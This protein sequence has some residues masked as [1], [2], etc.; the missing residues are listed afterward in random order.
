[1]LAFFYYIYRGVDITENYLAE[2]G[3]R[4]MILKLGAKVNHSSVPGYYGR[5]EAT[6]RAALPLTFEGIHSKED[7]WDW[8]ENR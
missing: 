2:R 8:F 4:E 1:M 3:M 7:F 6:P 5:F